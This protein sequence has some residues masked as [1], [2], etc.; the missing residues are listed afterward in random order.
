MLQ[1]G[2]GVENQQ[3]TSHLPS[4]LR[5]CA[6]MYVPSGMFSEHLSEVTVNPSCFIDFERASRAF[7][8]ACLRLQ[9]ITRA[10]GGLGS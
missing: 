8:M 9:L 5:K 1:V 7:K 4:T 3:Q 6:L 2:H 10:R